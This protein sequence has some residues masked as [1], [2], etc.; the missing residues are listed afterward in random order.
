VVPPSTPCTPHPPPHA[1]HTRT[2]LQDGNL[3]CWNAWAG[4]SFS[5]RLRAAVWWERVPKPLNSGRCAGGV[6]GVLAGGPGGG[7]GAGAGCGGG[8]WAGGA[9]GPCGGGAGAA[10]SSGCDA[11]A[12]AW[13]DWRD[14]TRSRVAAEGIGARARSPRNRTPC[15]IA[16]KAPFTFARETAPDSV[17]SQDSKPSA[18]TARARVHAASS[19]R[20]ALRV[21]FSALSTPFT[22]RRG[23]NR[24]TNPSTNR[25]DAPRMS[26]KSRAVEVGWG[27]VPPSAALGHRP[28]TTGGAGV[29]GERYPA[30]P[31]PSPP[32]PSPH[33]QAPIFQLRV[34][35]GAL[36]VSALS[37][38][39]KGHEMDAR[40]SVLCGALGDIP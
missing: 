28:Q 3:S 1:P 16:T 31:P 10:G 25:S 17:R 36:L 27:C 35:G 13:R 22:F 33:T 14:C 18:A 32:P 19:S 7:A 30:S 40:G 15:A 4:N 6:A 34:P 21:A 23:R 20:P 37:H 8:A 38:A 2:D 5:A 9:A 39:P 12:S 11:G 26:T 24:L 29:S